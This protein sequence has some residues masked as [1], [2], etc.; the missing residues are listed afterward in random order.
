[1][2][3]KPFQKSKNYIEKITPLLPVTKYQAYFTLGQI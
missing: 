3:E 2:S 1:M